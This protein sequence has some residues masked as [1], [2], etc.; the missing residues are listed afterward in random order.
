MPTVKLLKLDYKEHPNRVA[1]M[2]HWI[3]CK[4]YGLPSVSNLQEHKPDKVMEN[5]GIKILW[6]F[7]IQTGKHLDHNTPGITI[8]GG[9]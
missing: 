1:A 4:K 3:C 9:K 7:R 2:L 5:D 8:I 6:D